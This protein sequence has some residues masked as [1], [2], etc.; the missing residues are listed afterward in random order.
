MLTLTA[1]DPRRPMCDGISRRGFLKL[2]ALSVGGLTLADLLRLEAQGAARRSTK[3]VIMVWLE[4]GPSHI[5]TYDMKPKAPA[6]IRGEWKPIATK[7]AGMEFCEQLPE[8]AKI[9]DQLAVI[10]SMSFVTP[11]HRAPEEL[12]SGFPNGSNRPALGSVV[13][14]LESDAQRQSTLPTYVQLDSLRTPPEGMSFPGYLGA[15]H[16]P[17]IPGKD[18]NS[19]TLSRDMTLERLNQRKELLRTFDGL[20]RE[21]DAAPPGLD[22]F[23]LRALEMVSSS[24]ARDAFDIS[25]EPEAVKTK[26]GPATQMLQARRLVEAGVKVVSLSFLGVEKGRREACGFGGGTWDTHG[27][28]FKCLGH[29]LP[30][31]DHALTALV[32][33]LRERGLDQDVAVVC[34]GEFGRAPKLTPNPNR[35]PGRNHWPQAG[36][37]LLAGGGL[38]VGQVIGATDAQGGRPTEKPYT[39]QN[40]MAT[41]YHSLGIDL[42]TTLTDP[43]GRPIYLLDDRQPVAELV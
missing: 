17:F 42:E 6:E 21:L 10:R 25:Q 24:K 27:N 13:S 3:A 9:A 35:T 14:R 15:A 20:N 40:V 8:Q 12:L 33:D 26:Y 32:T 29:L 41:L 36:F 28:N 19:L 7:V 34:W 30:Q 43:T 22:T 31:F 5:D 4:G 23:T 37:A 11:D 2:G 38:K 1:G 39:P 16:K 18:L